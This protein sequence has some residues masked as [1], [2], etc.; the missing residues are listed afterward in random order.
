MRSK[1]D[2]AITYGKS[3]YIHTYIHTY[4]LSLFLYIGIYLIR[5]LR[6]KTVKFER[7]F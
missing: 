5:I 4:T 2:V 6:L 1:A 7:I 3:T